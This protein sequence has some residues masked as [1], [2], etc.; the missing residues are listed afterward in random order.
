MKK[1]FI[2]LPLLIL[3]SACDAPQRTR[4]FNTE[5]SNLNNADTPTG[6]FNSGSA[7]GGSGD[8]GG[9]TNPPITSTPGFENCDLTQKYHSVSTGYF[10]ICQSTQDEKQIKFNPSLT[11]QQE[12]TCLIPTYKESNGSSTYIGNPQCT[13]TTSNQVISGQLYKDRSGFSNHPLNGVM[14]MKEGLV[15]EYMGC[16]QGYVNWPRNRCSGANDSYCAYWVPRCPYGAQS[17][18]A[19][20]AEG[21]NYMAYLCNTFKSKYSNAYVDIRLK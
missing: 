19:C 13:L 3:V 10:G 21:K 18:A 17:N 8:Q 11:S 14:V 6:N 15:P 16:M 20:D 7:G 9:T 2:L 4:I 1:T 5:S 12:R